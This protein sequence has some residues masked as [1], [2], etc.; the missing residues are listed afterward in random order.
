MA[1]FGL[2]QWLLKP[3]TSRAVT[4]WCSGTVMLGAGLCMGSLGWNAVHGWLDA[5]IVGLCVGGLWAQALALRHILNRPLKMA[6]AWLACGAL[7]G[8]AAVFAH[9]M[10]VHALGLS[11]LVMALSAA[12]IWAGLLAN[13]IR[14][15]QGSTAAACMTWAFVAAGLTLAAAS[16]LLASGHTFWPAGHTG[17]AWAWVA[18]LAPLTMLTQLGFLGLSLEK[19]NRQIHA[20]L[21]HQAHQTQMVH[22]SEQMAE[23]DRRHGLGGMAA[24]LAHE[25]S[26][27]LTNLYLITDRLEME[28]QDRGNDSLAPFIHDLQ[29][30][31][32]KAGELVGRIRSF[33]G[34]E[35]KHPTRVQ[36][37]QVMLDAE[38]L[39][40]GWTLT[41]GVQLDVSPSKE[42]L[43]VK[44]DAAQ[45]VQILTHLLRNAMQATASQGT[46]RVE[47]RA[48][49]SDATVHMAISDNGPGMTD[50]LYRQV[51][52]AF[53]STQT[54]GIGL[55]LTVAQSLAK[56]NGGR[57]V[58]GEQATQGAC[59]E[60]QLPA[61]D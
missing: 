51:S 31:A 12:C 58:L 29:R 1:L 35:N 7:S 47:F 34:S 45:L 15:G 21:A 52:T 32:Q 16:V 60:L 39:A 43:F 59:I 14:R 22:L 6:Q 41:D 3:T 9:E 5:V 11:G 61:V 48:W 23:I 26:Q 13:D 50:E 33:V 10:S 36:I 8:L 57:L 17:A 53:F 40:R 38:H 27:P 56:R 42:K 37:Q 25:L 18:V 24:S 28:L 19:M 54:Q 49:R 30:N 20:L 46:R 2:V 55:G 44:A 4:L